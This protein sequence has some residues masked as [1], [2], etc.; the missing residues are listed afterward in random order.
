MVSRYHSSRWEAVSTAVGGGEASLYQLL[1]VA[2][3]HAFASI[4]PTFWQKVDVKCH[5]G[6]AV[7]TTWGRGPGWHWAMLIP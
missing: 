5:D 4:Q 2:A 7:F 6:L 3:I 1:A